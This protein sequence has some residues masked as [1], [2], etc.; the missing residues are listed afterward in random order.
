[1][2]PYSARPPASPVPREVLAAGTRRAALASCCVLVLRRRRLV[3]RRLRRCPL[4]VAL[5][6]FSS[7]SVAALLAAFCFR[8]RSFSCHPRAARR[9]AS[10]AFRGV[11]APG[12]YN[13][14]LNKH[15][16]ES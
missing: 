1:M 12:G 11:P 8:F 3:R 7:W 6:C 9:P 10:P 15:V 16:L 2:P 13:V 5:S 14:Q 4:L